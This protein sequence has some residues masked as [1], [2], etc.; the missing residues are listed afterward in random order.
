[1]TKFGLIIVAAMTSGFL[2]FSGCSSKEVQ[3][4]ETTTTTS[5]PATVTEPTPV[6]ETAPA[7]NRDYTAAD[8][9]ASSGGRGR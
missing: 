2:F 5:A 6:A 9:G 4:T 8:L 7:A 3:R 1:M